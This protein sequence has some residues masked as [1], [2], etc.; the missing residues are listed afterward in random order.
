MHSGTGS[1]TELESHSHWI[2]RVCPTN[3]AVWGSQP[4]F[5]ME[6]SPMPSPSLVFLIIVLTGMAGGLI[7]I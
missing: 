3:P 7:N 1:T 2:G 6:P 4:I 5:G